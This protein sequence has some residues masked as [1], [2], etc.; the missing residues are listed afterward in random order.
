MFSALPSWK[1]LATAGLTAWW[2][3]AQDRLSPSD[4]NDPRIDPSGTA[5]WVSVDLD[6]ADPLGAHKLGAS[7][8]LGLHNLFDEAYRVHGSGIDAASFN[9]V[10]GLRLTL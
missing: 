3:T 8:N 6:F 1:H 5:G 9:M 7:W 2:A 4:Q 10:A